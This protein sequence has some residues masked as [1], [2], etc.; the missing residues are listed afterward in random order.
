MGFFFVV[1]KSLLNKW[2][3]KWDEK[4]ISYAYAEDLDFSYSYYK[5]AKKENLKCII[6]SRIKVKHNCSREWRVS[7]KKSTI[8]FII[9]R[10]Y[11]SYKHFNTISSRIRT[12]WANVG[13]LIERIIKRNKPVEFLKGM[14]YC[15]KYRSDIKKGV[16]HYELYD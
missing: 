16:L 15:D 2:D 11:L 8:M 1:R 14:Y 10:E 5:Q 3:I 12:K 9:N 4:L 7:S 13:V 6:D